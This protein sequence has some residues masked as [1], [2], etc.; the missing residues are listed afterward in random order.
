MGVKFLL[1][2]F[3]TVALARVGDAVAAPDARKTLR[4]A[5]PI[6]ETGFDPAQVSDTYSNHIIA[7]I[8]DPPLTYDYLAKPLKLVPNTLVAMPEVSSDQMTYTLRVKPGIYFADDIAFAGKKR[9]LV[10]ADYVYS[11][12]RHFDPKTKSKH[13]GDFEGLIAGMDEM[14]AS[15]KAGGKFDYDRPVEGLRTLDRYVF[16]IKLKRLEP[17]MQYMMGHMAWMAALAREVVEYYGDRIMEHPVGTGPYRLKQWTRSSKITLEAS[18]HYREDY[19][20]AAPGT[21]DIAGQ[22]MLKRNQGK[23]LPLIGN[24]VISIVEEVQPRWLAFLNEEHDFLERLP[25]DFA[26]IAIP[27]NRIAPNLD[28]RSIRM[29]QFPEM[30]LVFVIFNMIDPVIGGYAPHQVALRRAITMGYS[31]EEEIRIL[32][33]NQA[34]PA[35]QPIGPGAMGYD[36]EFRTSI[37]EYNLPRAKALLDMYGYI[38]RD[39]DGYRE[40]PDGRPLVIEFA[41]EPDS[42]SRQY[43]ELWQKS[44]N[45]LGIKLKFNIAKWPDNLK[46]VYAGQRQMWQLGDTAV[47]PDANTWLTQYFGPNEGDKGNLPRFKNAEFDLLYEKYRITSHGPDR[48]ALV[49]EM[50]RIIMTYA[51]VKVNVHRILTDMWHPWVLNYRR[52]GMLRSIWKYVDI[53]LERQQAVQKGG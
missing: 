38:D 4:Y 26:N 44:M 45:A 15:A 18:P 28:K 46:A 1:A 23:R 10:A 34:I 33:K 51:P 20:N 8:F 53:D 27:N 42:N 40:L 19:W 48:Q 47:I 7:A 17:N 31:N 50:V 9:E 39:G 25:N 3:I 30:A 13:F 6:A 12:K 5:F 37:A 2:V 41:T 52:H 32:R 11:I 22:E 16:Q 24:I 29:A 14:Y 43:N 36:P 21:D 49:R 35:H